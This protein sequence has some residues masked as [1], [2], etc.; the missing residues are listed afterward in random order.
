VAGRVI[1]QPY[2]YPSTPHVRR[3]GPGGWSDYQKYRPWL[4]DEFT[5][6]C[7][8]CLDREV[9]RDM[10]ERLHIDHFQP[11]A[12]RKDLR[13]EYTNL[14]YLCP[15]CNS[16]KS[17]SI[18]PDP[19]AVALADCLEV[20]GDGRIEA[21]NGNPDGEAL[22]DVL[23]L[24]DALTVARRRRMI[25]MLRSIAENNWPLFVEWMGFPENPPDLSLLPPPRNMK[26]EGVAQSFYEK[27]RREEL[28]EV[29]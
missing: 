28:P 12:L 17:D 4:R 19:C 1:P 13:Y 8:Y 21:K 3:H 7:V 27:K 26:P 25:G 16:Q 24:D 5:F 14:L 9:W 10:R 20:H 11:Q 6:R 18:L 23:A 22:I 15:A 2:A 29:Y